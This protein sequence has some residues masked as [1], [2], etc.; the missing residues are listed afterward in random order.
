MPP[1]A[2]DRN[3]LHERISKPAPPAAGPQ[4]LMDSPERYVSGNLAERGQSMD[5]IPLAMPLRLRHF[6]SMA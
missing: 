6:A 3:P 2:R 5:T 4:R 1:Y